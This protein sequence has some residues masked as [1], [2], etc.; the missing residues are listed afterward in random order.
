M[1]MVLFSMVVLLLLIVA[2]A[3][4]PMTKMPVDPLAPLIVL[5]T[6]WA[7]S[8]DSGGDLTGAALDR[9]HFDSGFKSGDDIGLNGCGTTSC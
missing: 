8:T 6:P 7:G 4:K 1:P 5:E 9:F 2:D 3:P